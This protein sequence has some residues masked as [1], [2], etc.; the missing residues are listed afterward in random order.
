MKITFRQSGGFAGLIQGCELDT[1]LLSVS[2][3]T[4]L[5]SL[6]EQ[7]GILEAKSQFNPEARDL[8]N[9]EITIE[10]REETVNL[11]FDDMTLPES[12]EEL[13]EYLQERT[14]PLPLS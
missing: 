6:V 5:Q 3:A 8:F 10:T 1:D 11:L 12:A 4:Q 2:E 9:Y 7:S 14:K 13:F